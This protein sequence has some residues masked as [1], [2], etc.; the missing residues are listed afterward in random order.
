MVFLAVVIHFIREKP[1]WH[2][3]LRLSVI[4]GGTGYHRYQLIDAF[5][6]NFSEW[7]LA[8]TD[9]TA[10]WGWGLQDTT[11]QCSLYLPG[12]LKAC[13]DIYRRFPAIIFRK[14]FIRYSRNFHMDVDSV[15]QGT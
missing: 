13:A 5:I 1:V 4:T 14:I 15:E 11:N 8:G 6:N 7:A 2:L 12:I 3:I 9:G 10:H